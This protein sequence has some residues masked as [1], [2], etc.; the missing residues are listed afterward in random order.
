MTWSCGA[1]R[2]CTNKGPVDLDDVD[3]VGPQ[4]RQRRE[5]GSEVVERDPDPRPFQ[6][7]ERVPHDVGLVAEEDAFG[8][9]DLDHPGS[10]PCSAIARVSR[11]QSLSC[12]TGSQL[13]LI[14]IWP[15]G[16]P[17]SSQVRA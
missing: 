1:V 13:R 9:L 14:A 7:R 16:S 17:A 2:K 6:G 10:S 15:N 3:R 11:P 4:V 5:T 8:D 12:E